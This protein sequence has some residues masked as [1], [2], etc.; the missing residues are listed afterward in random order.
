[1]IAKFAGTN[2]SLPAVIF[3]AHLDSIASGVN[4]RAPGADDDG[5]G[6]VTLLEAL[7]A[8]GSGAVRDLRIVEGL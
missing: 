1:M 6:S 5:S 2:S 4:G 7:R 3:G 8:L